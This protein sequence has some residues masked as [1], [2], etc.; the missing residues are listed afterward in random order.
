[1]GIQID[2]KTSYIWPVDRDHRFT[3]LYTQPMKRIQKEKRMI[4][5]NESAI[6]D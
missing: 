1:M 5:N 4:K 3:G 2:K 6:Y